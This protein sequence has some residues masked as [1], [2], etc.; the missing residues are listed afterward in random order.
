[1]NKPVLH[2]TGVRSGTAKWTD[3]NLDG[4]SDLVIAGSADDDTYIIKLY[5]NDKN[6][7]FLPGQTLTQFSG[8]YTQTSIECFDLN[9]DGY[10]DLVWTAGN[11]SYG[12]GGKTAIFYNNGN[13]TFTSDNISFSLQDAWNSFD[14]G[15]Y[16]NDYAPDVLFSGGEVF[17]HPFKRLYQNGY[18]E[19]M[20]SI[21]SDFNPAF[22]EEG[23]VLWGDYDNDGDMDILAS[24]HYKE[25]DYSFNVNIIRN[26]L[27]M[28]AGSFTA[29]R[30]PAAPVNIQTT[31]K[32]G[33]LLITWDK[34]TTDETPNLSYNVMLKK[35]SQILNAPKSDFIT[36]KRFFTENGNAGLNNFAIFKDLPV[37]TY[38]ISIQSVDGAFAG[39]P[40]SNITTVE[41]KNTKAFFSFDTVCYKA[42]TKLSDLSTST[43]KIIGRKWKYNNKIISTD[44]VAHFV[45]PHSGS[46]NITLVITDTDGTIDS[47]THAIKIIARPTASFSST[48]VCLG[49]TTSF[50][51]NSSRNGAG[52]VSWLWIYGNGEASTDSIPVNKVYG[53]AQTY[54][55]KLIET[56]SNGCADTLTKDVIVA[57][58]PNAVPSVN[59]K[60]TFCQGDSVLL[61]VENNPVY[62]YQWKLDNNDLTATNSSSLKVRLNSGNYT[63]KITN[64]LAN[65]IA[66][67]E[68]TNVTILP[69][70]APPDI[71]TSGNTQ[72]C[73]GDSVILSIS[74]TAGNNYRWKLNS[75]AIGDNKN[76]FAAKSSGPYSIVVTNSSGCASNSVNS[77]PVVVFPKPATPVVNYSSQTSFCSGDSIN[78]S[79]DPIQGLS[80]QWKNNSL[81]ILGA[82]NTLYSAKSSGSYL[83]SIR[84]SNDCSVSTSPINVLVLENP[85]KPVINLPPST[86]LCQG[87]SVSLSVTNTPGLTYM[88][89][90]D[91]NAVNSGSF[92]YYAKNRGTY[93][94][95]VSN[96]NKCS[97]SSLNS[98][99]VIVKDLPSL[100]AV[101]ISGDLQFCNGGSVTLSVPV[102]ADYSYAWRNASGLITNARTNSFQATTTGKY[103]LEISNTSGCVVKTSEVNVV[104]KPAPVKPVIDPGNYQ[105]GKCPGENPIKLFVSNSETLNS[106][107]WYKN[108][109][110]ITGANFSFYQEFLQQGKYIVEA[111]IG[112][113]SV[114]SEPLNVVFDDAPP[115]KPDV[116]AQGPSRWVL[117]CSNKGATSYRWYLNGIV[118]PGAETFQ[119]VANY[120]MGTYSVSISNEKGCFTIS[121]PVTIPVAAD[122]TGLTDID[123][124]TSIK[125]YPNPTPGLFTIEMDNNLYG[126]L[127]IRISNQNGSDVLKIRFEKSTEHFSSQIDLSGQGKGMYLINLKIDKYLSSR[128]L[129]IE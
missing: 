59:G 54:K 9:K 28:K 109:D 82:T 100:S 15:D 125:I 1:L 49:S 26:N 43:K 6:N 86:V 53:L 62:Y 18:P 91:G 127:M 94:V 65:C 124:F 71:S 116:L 55:T 77:I 40:W 118:I 68:A 72:F 52:T 36:G 37:D 96:S 22:S 35:G 50:V 17:S 120:K 102:S 81:N 51:N 45:F 34:V 99:P 29:N 98:V 108:S 123:P 93:T 47:V 64:P 79:V 129:I 87:D 5:E 106:Y 97:V 107:Q 7:G 60:T 75:G 74:N 30:L 13:K 24:A 48:T 42:A 89:K 114:L 46:D 67:S 128:K 14:I 119:Y 12:L 56:A 16:N 113:C 84:N 103:Q 2:F 115:V 83:V 85:A 101:N 90:L 122:I 27:I 39:G 63:V 104:V 70:P 126:D 11:S 41:I 25:S 121:D 4:W 57:A 112:D 111:R 88:W 95:A 110:K 20:F 69:L 31:L 73:Q 38:T 21:N 8:F 80:Y 23:S 3:Y 58:I 92:H 44:S 117:D 10:T 32:P 66:S 61:S 33:Q 19:K 76:T 78:L 105:A